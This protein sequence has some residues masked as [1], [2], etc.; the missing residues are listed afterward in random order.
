MTSDIHPHWK[1][2]DDSAASLPKGDDAFWP[3]GEV[4]SSKEK[5]D[6]HHI[7]I[8]GKRGASSLL[9][10]ISLVSFGAMF[11]GVSFYQGVRMIRADLLEGQ[12][13]DV[14]VEV[15]DAE[16]SPGSLAIEAGKIVEWKNVSTSNQQF[17]SDQLDDSG[18]PF[19]SSPL[20]P[21]GES[22]VLEIPPELGGMLLMI[23][24]M[25]LPTMTQTITVENS[26]EASTEPVPSLPSIPPLPPVPPPPPAQ[27]S[28]PSTSSLPSTPSTLSTPPTPSTPSIPTTPTP[29]IQ[30]GSADK[31]AAQSWPNILRINRFTVGS[32]TIPDFKP[33][34]P[35]HAARRVQEEWQSRSHTAA[36][37]Q[38]TT[39]PALWI[40]SALTLGTMPFFFRGQKKKN[41]S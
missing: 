2:T 37:R 19:V 4:S 18:A 12:I 10:F 13:P 21:Q 6:H 29:T 14:T 33:I 7:R 24:S 38:P 26:S 20:L 41:V 5:Q 40:L 39:G 1:S 31:P 25:F 28:L 16:F 3:E 22:Y 9:L 30:I 27:V 32:V 23:R 17:R 8:A 15:R 11:L 34:S 35:I 36:P